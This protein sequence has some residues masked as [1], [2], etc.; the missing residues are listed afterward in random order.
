MISALLA[1]L[2]PW[3]IGIFTL[4]GALWGWGQSKKA[5]G[6]K[7]TYIETLADSAKRQ[8]EGRDAVQDLRDAD[9]DA[10]AGRVRDN[11]DSW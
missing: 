9:R 8:K 6:R 4:L 1:E 10:L 5:E 11:S 7:E 2:L 3:A